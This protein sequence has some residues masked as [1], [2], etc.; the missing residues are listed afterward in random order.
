MDIPVKEPKIK[1]VPT[2]EQIQK[3]TKIPTKDIIIAR[4]EALP[5]AI[6]DNEIAQM[7]M[8]DDILA[9]ETE[10]KI[11][12]NRINMLIATQKDGEDKLVYR[13]EMARDA[14]VAGRLKKDLEYNGIKEKISIKSKELK[15]QKIGYF[16][17]DRKFKAAR[18]IAK[19]ME[20]K[21][22]F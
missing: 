12:E 14:A 19:M 1:D 10:R 7:R 4:L 21:N 9:L 2:E 6:K 15:E 18:T 8:D 3:E 22:D 17:L 20:V 13:N 16:F 11:I 5:D